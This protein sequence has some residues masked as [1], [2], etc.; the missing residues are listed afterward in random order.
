MVGLIFADGHVHSNPIKGMGIATIGKKFRDAGGW[1]M[2]LVSLP[3]HSLGFN[4]TFDDYLKTFEV[5]INECK[6]AK[7]L[8]LKVMCFAGIHPSAIENEISRDSKHGGKVLEKALGVV[9]HIAKLIREGI[10]DG[11]GEIGRPHYKAIPEAFVVNNIVMMYTLTLAKDLSAPVHLHLEQGGE[12]TAIDIDKI[13]RSIDIEKNRII[14]HHLDVVTAKASQNR[15][16]IF[17]IAGKYPI[18]K[19]CIKSLKPMYMIESDFI[20]DPKRP[21]VSSY[22]W[23]IIENQRKLLAEDLVDEEYLYKINIDMV[24]KLYSIE[25]PF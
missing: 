3:P 21:G 23:D 5:L 20:D 15:G 1:F 18:L 25:P 16:F 12:V 24:I 11:F 13:A 8:G 14:L 4:N 7:E 19:E 17:T 10:V 2:A 9:D 6:I 22:P